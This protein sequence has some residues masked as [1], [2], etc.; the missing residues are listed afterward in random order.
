MS[1]YKNKL[2][3]DEANKRYY[4]NPNNPKPTNKRQ[5]YTIREIELICKSDKTD[6]E[7][8]AMTGRSIKAVEICRCRHKN[9][10]I[11]NHVPKSRVS[12]PRLVTSRQTE[13]E[14]QAEMEAGEQ[15]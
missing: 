5:R 4:N 8:S 11:G 1:R 15:D 7:I 13:A 3:H 12:R 2:A 6:I 10:P 14:F 9:R